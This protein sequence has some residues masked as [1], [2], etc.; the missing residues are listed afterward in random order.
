MKKILLSFADGLLSR[1]QM[2]GIKGGDYGD[3]GGHYAR[4]KTGDC[5]LSVRGSDGEWE[6]YYGTCSETFITNLNGTSETK[7]YCNSSYGGV[8][9]LSSN[10]GVSRCTVGH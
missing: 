1:E 6:N 3:Y 7:C 2:R 8:P 10:G 4:C 5:S 9:D